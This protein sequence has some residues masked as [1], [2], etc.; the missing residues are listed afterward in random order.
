[1]SRRWLP[2]RHYENGRIKL[3]RSILAS[4]HGIHRLD[5]RAGWLPSWGYSGCRRCGT[6]WWACREHVTPYGD[7]GEGCFPLCQRCWGELHP[8]D[9][10]PYYGELIRH[11]ISLGPPVEQETIDAILDAVRR[12][13]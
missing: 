3:F 11:W 4:L 2:R 7:E 6:P 8:V 9:R 12:G 1:M 5:V 13:R 10:L